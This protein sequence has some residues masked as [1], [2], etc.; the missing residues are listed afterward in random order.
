M[1]IDDGHIHGIEGVRGGKTEQKRP[2]RA[3]FVRIGDR[4]PKPECKQD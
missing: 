4:C 2:G 1:T 3:G